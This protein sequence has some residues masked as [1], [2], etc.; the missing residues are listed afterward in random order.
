MNSFKE[1]L[2]A[3]YTVIYYTIAISRQ[4]SLIALIRQTAV[5]FCAILANWAA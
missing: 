4:Y 3:L 1:A 2:S 5:Y